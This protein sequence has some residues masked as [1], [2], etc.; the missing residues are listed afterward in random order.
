MDNKNA[1]IGF[2]FLRLSTFTPKSKRGLFSWRSL[3]HQILQKITCPYPFD[4]SINH[5]IF[6]RVTMSS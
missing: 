4:V 1:R 6:L 3:F 2:L 5:N